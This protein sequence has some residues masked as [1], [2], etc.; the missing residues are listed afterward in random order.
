MRR[1]PPVRVVIRL[2][3]RLADDLAC[4]EDSDAVHLLDRAVASDLFHHCV[5][6]AAE[7]EPS[8]GRGHPYAL[9]ALDVEGEVTYTESFEDVKEQEIAKQYKLV[10]WDEPFE[11]VHTAV[12]QV[13]G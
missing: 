10:S 12:K 6:D 5:I 9:T 3:A 7:I 1:E 11:Q 4:F 2:E 8:A 13:R